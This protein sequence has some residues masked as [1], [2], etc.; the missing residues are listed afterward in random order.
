MS[1]AATKPPPGPHRRPLPRGPKGHPLLG[2]TPRWNADAMGLL[3][4][5]AR[6]FGD[7]VPIRLGPVR[8]VV[9]SHPELVEEVLVTK[10]RSF[11]KGS[12]H[13]LTRSLLGNGL[14]SSEG[15]VWRRQRRLAQPAFHHRRIA[16]YAA[17]MVEYTRDALGAWRDGDTRELHAEMQRLTLAIAAKTLFDVDVR[18]DAADFGG[19]L[20]AALERFDGRT[21]TFVLM[22]PTSVP[23]PA[24]VR[25]RRA[26]ERLDALIYAIVAQRRAA[27]DDRGDLLSMLLAAR[28]EEGGAMDDRQVR[29]EVMT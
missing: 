16:A 1:T 26:L 19:A 25:F 18:G 9:L 28:D 8:F 27:R 4:T 3:T 21:S 5:C 7:V 6:E 17:T 10:H 24:N 12:S 2:H 15:D 29:D 20:A 13:R 22:L 23:L 14:L 11:S